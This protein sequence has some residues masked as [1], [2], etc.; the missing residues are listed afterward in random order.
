MAGKYGTRTR[1]KGVMRLDYPP[2]QM[3]GYRAT[4]AWQG[5]RRDKFFSDT[6]HGDRLGALAA[7][8]AWRDAIER[9]LGKPRSDAVVQGRAAGIWR[10]VEGQQAYWCAGWKTNDDR[11]IVTRFAV[12]KYGEVKAKRLAQQARARGERAR[13][14]A[15]RPTIRRR[16]SRL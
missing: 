13:L 8:V 10:R 6:R 5:T 2:R 16:G 12:R 9:Q 3:H 1:H 4:V 15:G 11:R 7:A 14:A